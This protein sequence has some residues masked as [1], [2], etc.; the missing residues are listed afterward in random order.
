MDPISI[1]D[2]LADVGLPLI[3]LDLRSAPKAGPV[4]D[5]LNQ[6]K[7][8]RHQDRYGELVPIDAFD[9]FLFVESLSAVHPIHST[10]FSI[11]SHGHT[12]PGGKHLAE[13]IAGRTTQDINATRVMW[14]FFREN[15]RSS[16]VPVRR[17][18]CV[19]RVFSAWCSQ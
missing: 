3:A 1:D 14:A 5:W 16:Y 19:S 11:G 12:W 13:W 15:P 2:V 9:V 18:S 17:N 8:I 10:D 6:G 4:A 7:K